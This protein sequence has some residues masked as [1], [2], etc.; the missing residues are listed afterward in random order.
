MK[1]IYSILTAILMCMPLMWL[2]SCD[3][4]YYG[5]PG[6]NY[7]PDLIGYWQLT[8]ANGVP[9]YGYKSNFLEFFRN[10][11]G[12]YYYYNYGQAYEMRL[13]Y[14]LDFYAGGQTI[15]INYEDGSYVSADYWFNSNASRLYM[16]WFEA[17]GEVIYE[18]TYVDGVSWAPAAYALASQAGADTASSLPAIGLRPGGEV[19]R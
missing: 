5:P 4:E 15:Y 19:K 16:R 14:S 17:G 12:Y 11:T 13:T 1:K 9:V 2:T 18:Y 6:G 7:D 3:D 8:R 10:G